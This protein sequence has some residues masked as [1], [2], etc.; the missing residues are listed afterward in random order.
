MLFH[1]MA[2]GCSH[3]KDLVILSWDWFEVYCHLNLN[4]SV[5]FMLHSSLL[6][7]RLFLFLPR[8]CLLGSSHQE[9]AST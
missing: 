1:G 3:T 7:G 8:S 2:L 6:V 4:A 5:F 9:L